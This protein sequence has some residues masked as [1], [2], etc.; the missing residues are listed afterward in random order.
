M[1]IMCEMCQKTNTT[2]LV[3]IYGTVKEICRECEFD[4]FHPL[5]ESDYDLKRVKDLLDGKKSKVRDDLD[6]IVRL[7][8]ANVRR[9]YETIVR[10]GEKKD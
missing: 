3:N 10:A 8:T 7:N 4:Y 5:M 2:V 1:S 9:V 6:V